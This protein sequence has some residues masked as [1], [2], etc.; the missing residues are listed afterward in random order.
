MEEA[1]EKISLA[2]GVIER[3][4]VKPV[5]DKKANGMKDARELIKVGTDYTS[6]GWSQGSP[7]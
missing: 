6:P 5:P 2:G 3:R 1:E 7:V 4:V